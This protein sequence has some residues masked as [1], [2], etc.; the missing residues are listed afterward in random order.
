MRSHTT[1]RRMVRRASSSALS[2]SFRS[3]SSRMAVAPARHWS[4]RAPSS[5][6]NQ[7]LRSSMA[8]WLASV[9][10]C[11]A[12]PFAQ[13]SR[14]LLNAR[15]TFRSANL[16]MIICTRLYDWTAASASPTRAA[17]SLT[18]S[19]ASGSAVCVTSS[20]CFCASSSLSGL[21]SGLSSAAH[22]RTLS[23]TVLS[24]APSPSAMPACAAISPSTTAL[25]K[26]TSWPS[27]S[28]PAPPLLTLPGIRA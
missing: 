26:S 2:A 7:R 12:A 21:S 14:H 1:L 10:S 3:R 25:R 8:A 6:L 16:R 28:S 18:S 22:P 20:R 27:S 17:A 13:M 5:L 11:A 24:H 19:R 4:N 9:F 15:A 23:L